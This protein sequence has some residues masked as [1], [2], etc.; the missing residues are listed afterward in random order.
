MIDL[1]ETNETAKAISE[2]FKTCLKKCNIIEKCAAFSADNCNTNFDG[3]KRSAKNN[4]C[5]HLKIKSGKDLI[6]IG[7]LAHIVH[8]SAQHG[9]DSM[10]ID[11]ESVIRK[12]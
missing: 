8:D 9:F 12:L 10:T 3:L 6:G 2:D 7:C 1:Y 11:L 4:V 5:S